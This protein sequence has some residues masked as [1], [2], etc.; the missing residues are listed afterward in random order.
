MNITQIF[1]LGLIFRFAIK[2]FG[3]LFSSLYKEINSQSRIIEL[4]KYFKQSK[5]V[6]EQGIILQ[7]E[8][9]A[10]NKFRKEIKIFTGLNIMFLFNSILCH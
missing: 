8:E 6:W 10:T 7:G 1:M 4:S 5:I 2:Q 9:E 3:R